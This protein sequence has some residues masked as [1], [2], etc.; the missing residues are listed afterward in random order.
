MA[1]LLRDAA[2]LR[3]CLLLVAMLAGFAAGASLLF[4]E[5]RRGRKD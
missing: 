2:F 5:T 4:L 1:S 3:D